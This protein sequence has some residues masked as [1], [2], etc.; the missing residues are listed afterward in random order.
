M[1]QYGG[2]VM[3]D[4]VIALIELVANAWDA[5]ATDVNIT[6]GTSSGAPT[7]VVEDNGHGMTAAQLAERYQT[8]AYQRPEG[9]S[10]YAE[11]PS[12]LV[13]PKRRV[14][15]RNGKGRL[16]ALC[17]G[18]RVQLSTWRDGTEVRVRVSRGTDGHNPLQVEPD[19]ETPRDGHG[20]RIEVW[21]DRPGQLS[22]EIARGELALRFLANPRFSVT[23]NGAPVE[24]GSV[25][26]ENAPQTTLT[27]P[28]GGGAT[29]TLDVRMLVSASSDRAARQTGVAWQVHG[30]QV[31]DCSW[32]WLAGHANIDGRTYG[33][34]RVTLIVSAD[35]LVEDVNEYWT[36][37]DPTQRWERARRAV[38]ELAEEWITRLLQEQTQERRKAIRKR[39][40]RELQAMPLVGREQWDKFIG[41]VLLS[42]PTLGV[43]ELETI[44]SVLAKLELSRNKYDLIEL[45]DL[46]Q[47][48]DLD[49]LYTTLSE[50]NARSVRIIVD[51]L[52]ERLK[53]IEQLSAKVRDQKAD[54][55]QDLQPLFNRGLWIFGPEYESIEFTSNQNITTVLRKLF[56]VK[57]SPAVSRN[58]PDF[59][60]VENGSLGAYSHDSYD[61]HNGEARGVA[62]VVIV[63]LKAPGVT[64]GLE[65]VSQPEK[66]VYELTKEGAI[67]L[68]QTE[69][70]CFVLGAQSANI[71]AQ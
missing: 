44:A 67:T 28:D 47:P 30:R 6:L 53:L 15:G 42:C 32:N 21:G 40:A 48:S 24:F 68:G 1:D 57:A 56:G 62:R 13:L 22:A 71:T 52:S 16:A 4:P 20:T 63:E 61:E 60:V 59:V 31:G 50:W 43:K 58:R 51:E 34:R 33:A 37:F 14:F 11:N 45:L 54:E 10:E 2:R 25:P 23:V 29:I 64:I 18:E 49:H 7:L 12:G 38:G 69:V 26:N 27:I 41:G 65:E 19:G 35:E 55:L 17:F 70:T 9:Q 5:N 36:S 3:R 46:E 39:H 8:F 66:Y